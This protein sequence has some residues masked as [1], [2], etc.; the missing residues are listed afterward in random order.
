MLMNVGELPEPRYQRQRPRGDDDKDE[1]VRA[2]KGGVD[3]QGPDVA[4]TL[5]AATNLKPQQLTVEI[6][7]DGLVQSAQD[8]IVAD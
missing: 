3:K 6:S 4:Y 1:E 7:G 5:S 2:S 8:E